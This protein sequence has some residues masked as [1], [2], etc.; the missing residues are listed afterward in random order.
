MPN[1]IE[2]ERKW[3]VA[4]YPRIP[5]GDPYQPVS[6]C[7]IWQGYIEGTQI[8]ERVRESHDVTANSREY[9]RTVKSGHGLERIE[10]EERITR[11]QFER[12]RDVCSYVVEK[13]RVTFSDGIQTI[14][15]DAFSTPLGVEPYDHM[16]RLAEIELAHP[17]LPD[18]LTHVVV[19]EV[20]DD[21]NFE[22]YA[23][24]KRFT[25]YIHSFQ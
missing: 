13:S 6:S 12:L 7:N 23:I 1:G 18:W 22:N 10:L 9:T 14:T 19:R 25:Q 17:Q 11:S 4:D 24:A 5:Q 21:P 20:T 3:L 8:I 15:L 16:L 2:I